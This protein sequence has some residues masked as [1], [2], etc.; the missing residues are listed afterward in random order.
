M[1][2]VCGWGLDVWFG[3]VCGLNDVGWYCE[4]GGALGHAGVLCLLE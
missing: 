3:R 2:R 1:G 4:G